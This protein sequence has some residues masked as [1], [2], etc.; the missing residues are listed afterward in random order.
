MITEGLYPIGSIWTRIERTRKLW[1]LLLPDF[2]PPSQE[3]LAAWCATYPDSILESAISQTHR[4][5]KRKVFESSE[6]AHKYTT[7]TCRRLSKE[8]RDG[9]AHPP[10]SDEGAL[11]KIQELMETK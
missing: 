7:A 5:S 3:W 4:A 11:S 1:Q 10:I 8:Q 6:A 2:K 9:F